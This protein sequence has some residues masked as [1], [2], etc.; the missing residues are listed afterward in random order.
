MFPSDEIFVTANERMNQWIES[1]LSIL[2]ILYFG[3]YSNSTS[4]H[5]THRA[6]LFIMIHTANSFPNCQ[7][8]TT[9]V[10]RTCISKLKISTRHWLA[11]VHSFIL[12]SCVIFIST[13]YMANFGII[14]TTRTRVQYSSISSIILYMRA[15]QLK[16]LSQ[17]MFQKV[18]HIF[19]FWSRKW[20][21]SSFV[22]WIYFAG[23]KIWK[24]H[25]RA[26]CVR[27]PWKWTNLLSMTVWYGTYT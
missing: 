8:P 27:T 19:K 21:Q 6:L 13:K 7:C 23:T 24:G 10:V 20:I 16:L 25:W 5:H 17:N 18:V 1:N 2:R 26:T 12:W 15:T 11:T 22:N 3:C 9:H 14:P 4:Q